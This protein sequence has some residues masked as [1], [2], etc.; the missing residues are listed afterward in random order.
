MPVNR[1]PVNGGPVNRGFTVHIRNRVLKVWYVVSESLNDYL[2]VLC[3]RIL[4]QKLTSGYK[5]RLKKFG[6][7]RTN[8]VTS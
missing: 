3:S 4:N 6:L 8:D 5:T 2:S 1:G 7:G